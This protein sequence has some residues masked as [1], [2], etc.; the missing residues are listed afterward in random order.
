MMKE[1]PH[2]L[3]R[4]LPMA[5]GHCPSC[6]KDMAGELPPFGKLSVTPHMILPR[7][8]STCGTSTKN[9]ELLELHSHDGLSATQRTAAFAAAIIFL[10]FLFWP[11]LFLLRRDTFKERREARF[12]IPRCWE[13]R[14]SSGPLRVERYNPDQERA[15]LVVSRE[16]LD[17]LHST[18]DP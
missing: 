5:N 15:V 12:E 14:E 6:T 17:A 4:V 11:L 10:R 16:F 3:A 9:V 13:C 8:C 7:V 18:S 1:C 2:C